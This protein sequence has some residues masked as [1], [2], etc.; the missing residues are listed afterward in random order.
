MRMALILGLLLLSSR[1]VTFTIE[2]DMPVG[3]IK[4]HNAHMPPDPGKIAY[5]LARLSVSRYS[6]FVSTVAYA[7]CTRKKEEGPQVRSAA[8]RLIDQILGP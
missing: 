7:H 8:T 3:L 6:P 1:R 2:K 4:L 5:L